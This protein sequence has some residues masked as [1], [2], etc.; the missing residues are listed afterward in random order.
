MKMCLHHQIWTP[1]RPPPPRQIDQIKVRALF[2][3]EGRTY[4]IGGLWAY[5]VYSL[6]GKQT[7]EQD[8]ENN[9]ETAGNVFFQK[10]PRAHRNKI[11]TLF[12]TRA[13]QKRNRGRDSQPRPRTS[14]ELSTAGP[15][16]QLRRLSQINENP[17]PSVEET[18]G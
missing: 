10:H 13:E 17:T 5:P 15:K 18:P 1:A 16:G 7:K 9:S 12:L 11:G 14:I 4:Y 8:V 3:G 6:L 2:L